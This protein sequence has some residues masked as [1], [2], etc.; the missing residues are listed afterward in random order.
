MPRLTHPGFASLATPSLLRKE[1]Y[2]SSTPLL[3]SIEK[4][5]GDELRW[6]LIFFSTLTKSLF[7]SSFVTRNTVNFNSSIAWSRALS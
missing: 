1:G 2:G 4:G 6:L 7:T 3:Y 5:L